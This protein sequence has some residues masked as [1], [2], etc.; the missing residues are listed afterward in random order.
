MQAVLAGQ[1]PD[2]VPVSMWLHNFARE[3][4]ADD[5]IAETLR[6][7]ERF[8]FDF[9]KPQSPW[10][11]ACVLW[12]TE[13]SR[14]STAAEWP[15]VTKYAVNDPSDLARI[16]RKPV[17]G[18]L[19]DQIRVMRDVRQAFGPDTPVV[20]TVFSPMMTLALMNSRGKDGA[21]D[22]M[23][24]HPKDLRRALANIADTLTDF[25][26][27][28]IADGVDGVFY[29]TKTCNKGDISRAEHDEFHAPFDKQILDACDG[30]WMNIL[31]LCGPEVLTE[32]F[33]DYSPPIISWE[34]TPTNPTMTEMR[35]MTGKVVLTGAPAKPTF[36][37]TS[38]SRLGSG[39]RAA[40]AEL[41]G[42]HQLIGP[43]CS[44]NPGVDE[45]LIAAVVDATR[46]PSEHRV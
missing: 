12:G 17:I 40:I 15:V 19:A 8:H 32:Y 18:M 20:A 13:V 36:A 31:H 38:A 28:V 45:D 24:T 5:L 27:Q 46:N 25:T 42:L 7:Q 21:L 10:Q 37:D 6:L 14:P 33:T 30:G 11:S 29:A 39:V 34:L 26:E 16:T 9:F 41:D 35:E 44:V 2:R 22:M 4:D 3:Q 1:R 23:R 43:G